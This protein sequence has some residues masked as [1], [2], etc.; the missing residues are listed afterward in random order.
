MFRYH[1]LN[2][3]STFLSNIELTLVIGIHHIQKTFLAQSFKYFER[4]F[5]LIKDANMIWCELYF[6]WK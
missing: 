2:I 3:A 1:C 4:Y 6:Y 5:A